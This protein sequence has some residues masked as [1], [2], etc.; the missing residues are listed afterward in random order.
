MNDL[1]RR[2]LTGISEEVILEELRG[3]DKIFSGLLSDTSL[4]VSVSSNEVS[5]LTSPRSEYNVFTNVNKL[6]AVKLVN[7]P[8]ISNY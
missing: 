1:I 3:E 2:K 7:N 4:F 8:R 5:S 6:I